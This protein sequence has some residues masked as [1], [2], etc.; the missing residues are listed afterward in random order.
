MSIAVMSAIW[1]NGPNDQSALLVM[2]VLGDHAD[3]YGT[4]WP[5][6][7]LVASKARMSV[8]N[9]RRVVR[10]L[11]ADG[12]ISTQIGTGRGNPTRF[13]IKADKL[14]AFSNRD[15]KGGQTE[16]ER[17]TNNALKGDIAMSAEPSR[18]HQLEPSEASSTSPKTSTA[19]GKRLNDDW[20]PDE[21]QR[22]YARQK[23]LDED[24]INRIAEDFAD[25]WIAK[26]GKDGRKVDWNR[27]WQKWVRTDADRRKERADR[28][29]KLVKPSGT[30][31]A[32][33]AA[34]R[35]VSRRI[36]GT[37]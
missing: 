23:G 31:T 27:T 3:D 1:K 18:N 7:S 37:C 9:V 12:W 25:Y 13:K 6:M 36:R 15:D 28:A 35:A 20:K 11:E 32:R 24:E 14:T 4:C 10:Q 5:S 21:S 2:L 19:V 16:P 33:D 8:R 17:G 30:Q 34:G 26:P 22:E 29:A